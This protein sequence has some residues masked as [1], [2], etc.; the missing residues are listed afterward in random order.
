[1]IFA[2]LEV[3]KTAGRQ[4]GVFASE[5]IENGRKILDF[6]GRIVPEKES[7]PF[8]LQ[9][10][11]NAVIRA[12][13]RN[14]TDNFLNHSCRPNAFVKQAGKRF[15]LVAAENIE[16]GAEITFDYDTTDY[17]NEEFR[18]R[19]RCG[20]R[21]CRK[22]IRGFKY[23]DRKQKRRLGRWLIPYLKRILENEKAKTS[24]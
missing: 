2:R 18:F 7:C 9:I 11:K 10:S 20:S 16:E 15:Y 12:H 23:L 1:M 14:Q 13:S 19:C 21:K 24:K 6:P 8:D 3:R 17:D 4:K 22:I 5:N